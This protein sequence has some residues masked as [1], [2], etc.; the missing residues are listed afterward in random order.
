MGYLENLIVEYLARHP[1]PG[2]SSKKIEDTVHVLVDERDLHLSSM[3]GR[4]IEET[5]ASA[6]ATLEMG[7][8]GAGAPAPVVKSRPRRRKVER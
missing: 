1:A 3:S 4:A 8:G 7:R 6:I 2:L 5:I